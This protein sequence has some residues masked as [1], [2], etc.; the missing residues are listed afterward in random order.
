MLRDGC[1]SFPVSFL[2][3]FT[4][5]RE[6]SSRAWE[7]VWRNADE[8]PPPSKKPHADSERIYPEQLQGRDVKMTL[9]VLGGVFLTLQRM[10][11]PN[12]IP[13]ADWSDQPLA[14]DEEAY[15]YYPFPPAM[16]GTQV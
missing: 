15:G 4:S 10:L 7:W 1:V 8:L 13:R 5:G 16:D 11:E 9:D 2:L 6:D 14:Y 12:T 3:S